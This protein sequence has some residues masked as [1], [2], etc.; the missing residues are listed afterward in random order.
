MKNLLK[1]NPYF[2]MTAFECIQSKVFDPVRDINKEKILSYM[3]QENTQ[4]YNGNSQG[5]S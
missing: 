1:F 2:R 5:S 4:S 3:H